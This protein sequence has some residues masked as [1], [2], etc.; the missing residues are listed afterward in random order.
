M[1]DIKVAI[2]VRVSTEEQ[3]EE[4]YSI[5]AQLENLRGFCKA[6]GYSIIKEYRDEGISGKSI[7]GRKGIQSLLEDAR[8]GI[9]SNV[10]VWKTSRMSRVQIDLLQIVST[11]QK[12]GIG[13]ISMTEQFDTSSPSGKAMFQMLGTF[14]E[15]ERNQL[16]E[17]VKLGMRQKARQGEWCGGTILGYDIEEGKLIPNEKEA[18]IVQKIFELYCQCKGLKSI[19]NQMNHEGYT[20]K[21]GNPF[22]VNSIRTILHNPTYI[23]KIRWNKQNN[24]NEK[25]RKGTQEPLIVDGKHQSIISLE[26]WDT[27]QD[28]INKKTFTPSRLYTGKFPLAGFLRCPKC[29]AGMVGTNHT[30]QIKSGI[31]HYRN[32]VCGNFHYKIPVEAKKSPWNRKECLW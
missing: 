23:G 10:I 24:W 12:Q 28:L 14:A 17:N 32:Y 30:R 18:F 1:K 3:A 19:A 20:G 25:R 4:G 31:V 16:A 13:F 22:S 5:D 9:F 7:Q 26:T 29:G 8:L 21:N 11:L 2:Y 15:F 27:A 6:K